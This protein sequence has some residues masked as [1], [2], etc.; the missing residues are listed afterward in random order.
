MYFISSKLDSDL[1]LQYD[2]LFFNQFSPFTIMCIDINEFIS[3]ILFWPFFFLVHVCKLFVSFLPYCFI[4]VLF[5]WFF[6]PLN[7][8]HFPTFEIL[9]SMLLKNF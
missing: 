3:T 5:F 9:P 1:I 7:S 2:N 6:F 8:L 4:Q